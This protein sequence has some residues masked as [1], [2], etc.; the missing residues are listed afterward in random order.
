[1]PE[2]LKRNKEKLGPEAQREILFEEISN[3]LM[4]DSDLILST[5]PDLAKSLE[6]IKDAEKANI[7]KRRILDELTYLRKNNPKAE[8]SLL[9]TLQKGDTIGDWLKENPKFNSYFEGSIMSQLKT[10]AKAAKEQGG[11]SVKK[12]IDAMPDKVVID[13]KTIDISGLKDYMKSPESAMYGQTKKGG[14]KA[15]WFDEVILERYI[16]HAVKFA[17]KLPTWIQKMANKEAVLQTVGLGTSPTA[18]SALD[19][20]ESII[21]IEKQQD[22]LRA[23]G[24]VED[25]ISEEELWR[26]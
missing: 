15:N 22:R 4:R 20:Q 10:I 16:N 24:L 13:G 7:E 3:D 25:E 6:N 1:M 18:K 9:Q 5:S 12:G 11:A 26:L 2:A 19:V 21:R 23:D 14:Q 17:E 8:A